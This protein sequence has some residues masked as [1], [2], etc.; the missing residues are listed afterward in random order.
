MQPIKLFKIFLSLFRWNALMWQ[1]LIF[2]ENQDITSSP[3]ALR[4][5]GGWS[6]LLDSGRNRFSY[7][8]VDTSAGFGGENA[9]GHSGA[10]R[11][12]SEA[13][14][15]IK[16]LRQRLSFICTD[17]YRTDDLMK[18]HGSIRVVR[19]WCGIRTDPILRCFI[20]PE[21]LSCGD[22][23][24]SIV[25]ELARS[26]KLTTAVPSQDLSG[27]WITIRGWEPARASASP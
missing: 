6:R 10:H 5:A 1:V 2:S 4:W 22:L 11:L 12:A 14:S 20:N 7:G 27:A 8:I 16:K 19:K 25:L 26:L 3:R 13:T 15:E 18:S 24:V 23:L 21:G 17:R 9:G